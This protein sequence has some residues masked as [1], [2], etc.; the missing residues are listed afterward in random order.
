MKLQ[1][2]HNYKYALFQEFEYL[3]ESEHQHSKRIVSVHLK[4]PNQR[5]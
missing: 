1:A 3:R 5:I 4:K 2:I